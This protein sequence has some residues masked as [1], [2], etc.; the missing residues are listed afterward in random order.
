MWAQR[1]SPR[2][3]EEHCLI[4]LDLDDRGRLAVAVGGP[5]DPT[6]LDE[7]RLTLGRPLALV[8]APAAEIRAAVLSSRGSDEV[9][10]VE[11]GRGEGMGGGQFGAALDDL[12]ALASEAP[13][14]QLVNLMLLEA[15][16]QRA[17]DVHLESTSEGLK[18]RQ[19][20]DGVLHDVA[21]HPMRYQAAVISRVKIMANLDIAERRVPQDG[22]VRLKLSDRELDVRVSTLPAVHGEGVVLRLLDRTEDV[23]TLDALG[24]DED[25]QRGFSRLLRRPNGIIL[26]TGPT[27]SGKTTTLYAALQRVA[28]PELKVITVEDPVEYQIEGLTQ[29]AVDPRAGR[30]FAA[31]LRSILRHDPDVVMVGEMRDRETAEIAIQAALTGHLVLSTLHTNDA[32]SGVTRLVDMGAEPYLL[33][34]T[35]QGI[36]AQRLMRR[37]CDACREPHTLDDFERR[38]AERLGLPDA[39]TAYARGAGCE[40]CAGTGYRG[41]MGVYELMPLTERIRSLVVRAEPL[42]RIRAA[43]RE[44]GMVPLHEAAWTRAAE[45]LTSVAEVARVTGEEGW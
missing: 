24:M 14:I 39:G 4:P 45:G 19:R 28:T 2:Y 10:A 36:L 7:L 38:W 31:T 11:T 21:V 3:M 34:A 13:V 6:V 16:R 37:V 40:A 17:S 20:I 44:E 33:A 1:L 41:R 43:A 23:L 25:T 32:P 5:L 27:G 42:D 30:T 35:I 15:L 12:R 22:R 18:V 8:D 26:V 29:V 9:T